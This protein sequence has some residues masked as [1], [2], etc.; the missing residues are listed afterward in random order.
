MEAKFKTTLTVAIT[1]YKPTNKQIDNWSNCIDDIFKGIGENKI[2]FIFL[3]DNPSIEKWVEEK[4]SKIIK[5]YNSVIY[6]PTEENVKRVKTVLNNLDIV[7]SN[8]LKFA[9]PDDILIPKQ[10]FK[11]LETIKEINLNSIILH[12]YNTVKKEISYPNINKKRRF[13]WHA[14]YNPNT[15]YPV[16][17][18]KKIN[19]RNN[20]LIWSDDLLGVKTKLMGGEITKKRSI[21]FYL[22]HRHAGVSTVKEQS[23]SMDLY[24][25]SIKFLDEIIYEKITEKNLIKKMTGKPNL[26]FIKQ[27]FLSLEMN[28][29]LNRFEKIDLYR[30]LIFKSNII[31]ENIWLKFLWNKYL[32]KFS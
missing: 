17:I 22:N 11:D 18:L 26:F 15:I 4:I 20:F 7:T 24:N 23:Y 31:R 6:I 32:N 9:D 19:W 30:S 27:N 5:K 1:L 14:S 3:S 2:Q 13:F 28:K 8:F 12:S 10:L 16:N 29:S 25:D 21:S